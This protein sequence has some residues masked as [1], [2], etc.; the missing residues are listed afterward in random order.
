MEAFWIIVLV[1]LLYNFEMTRC[2]TWYKSQLPDTNTETD[3]KW[4]IKVRSVT[5]CAHHCTVNTNC[6]SF[7]YE[8]STTN[9][10]L[11]YVSNLTSQ[12]VNSIQIS[13]YSKTLVLNCPN[14]YDHLPE[15][16]TC[17]KL[18]PNYLTWNDSFTAC[19]NDDADL[20]VLDTNILFD[21]FQDYMDLWSSNRV[22]VNAK[23]SNNVPY[24]ETGGEVNASK[25]CEYTPDMLN[26]SDVCLF[27]AHK[28]ESWCNSSLYRLDDALCK[29]YAL[30]I[31]MVKL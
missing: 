21:E 24:W 1:Y 19:K 26:V 13:H 29:E 14:G 6:R 16:N 4:T 11:L 27:L 28:S 23:L 17:V 8:N 7:Q 9:C 31:C 5:E 10:T 2:V 12:Y 25:F 18:Y 30:R 22:A 20:P 15:S 3:I